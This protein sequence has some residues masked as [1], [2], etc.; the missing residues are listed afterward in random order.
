MLV[1]FLSILSV[2]AC[3]HIVICFSAH[4]I[5]WDLFLATWLKE[6]EGSSLVPFVRTL[7]VVESLVNSK[8]QAP[9][10]QRSSPFRERENQHP[11]VI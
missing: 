5:S 7:E 10:S 11:L 4:K 2:R 8:N 9:Y 1:A 3:G 6:R